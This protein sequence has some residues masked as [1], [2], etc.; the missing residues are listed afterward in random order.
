MAQ[1]IVLLLQPRQLMYWT[2]VG[3]EWGDQALCACRK[4]N[5]TEE[6]DAPRVT[7][8]GQTDYQA[9]SE[10]LTSRSK[11]SQLDSI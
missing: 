1:N 6:Q 4:R 7:Q 5:P 10:V 3:K 8:P 11:V 2:P 9:R